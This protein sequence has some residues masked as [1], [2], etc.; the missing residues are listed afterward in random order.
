MVFDTT[1]VVAKAPEQVTVRRNLHL[2]RN[3]ARRRRRRGSLGYSA[4]AIALSCRQ[5]YTE[6]IQQYYSLNTFG[7]C[8]SEVCEQFLQAIGFEKA[9]MIR[10]IRFAQD[11]GFTCLYPFENLRTLETVHTHGCRCMNTE[12]CSIAAAQARVLC[13]RATR[14]EKISIMPCYCCRSGD[15]CLLNGATNKYRALM[16]ELNEYLCKRI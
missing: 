13:R 16:E 10:H 7:I 1:I 6:S 3:T 12:V 2:E 8:N 9:K 15:I 14:L 11:I 5:T 4:L